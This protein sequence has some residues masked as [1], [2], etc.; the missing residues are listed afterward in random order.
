MAFW[1]TEDTGT[2]DGR[3][4]EA[5]AIAISIE[6][7]VSFLF[8]LCRGW[9]VISISALVCTIVQWSSVGAPKWRCIGTHWVRG[10]DRRKSEKLRMGNYSLDLKYA[11]NGV[12]HK[13]RARARGWSF[14]RL[15]AGRKE[16]AR[17]DAE[18]KLKRKSVKF[19]YGRWISCLGLVES[20]LKRFK[21][22]KGDHWDHPTTVC[23]LF[24][25]FLLSF[26]AYFSINPWDNCHHPTHRPLAQTSSRSQQRYWRYYQLHP[27]PSVC[28]GT[29]AQLYRTLIPSMAVTS[30]T[31]C[32]CMSTYLVQVG[33]Q[34]FSDT[35]TRPRPLQ[36]VYVDLSVPYPLFPF[37]LV[38][39]WVY[40]NSSVASLP[41]KV[42]PELLTLNITW[43]SI[44]RSPLASIATPFTT[45]LHLPRVWHRIPATCVVSR[46]RLAQ[47]KLRDRTTTQQVST[48]CRA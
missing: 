19:A 7:M 20:D 39:F 6:M 40:L 47:N 8:K 5:S 16:A 9:F 42:L 12:Q 26:L 10:L 33:R 41:N 34:D 32:Q 17:F 48:P 22:I 43:F 23:L 30:L 27:K 11:Y 4:P 1:W 45:R 24:F 3:I 28:S 46:R 31:Y 25:D 21:G 29:M 38:N 14:V 15:M 13:D 36:V 37:T 2:T 44:H 18:T 35:D